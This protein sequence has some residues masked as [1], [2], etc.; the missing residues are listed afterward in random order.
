MSDA[1]LRA[2]E[3][4]ARTGDADARAKW[5]V[6]RVRAGTL[7]RE[8]L[9]AAAY[10][11]DEGARLAVLAE[12]PLCECDSSRR[13]MH[14]RTCPLADRATRDTKGALRIPRATTVWLHNLRGDRDLVVTALLA[15]LGFFAPQYERR[16]Q[17]AVESLGLGIRDWLRCPCGEHAGEVKE[18]SA[19]LEHVLESGDQ[20][21]PNMREAHWIALLWQALGASIGRGVPATVPSRW[22]GLAET[23]LRSG[24]TTESGLRRTIGDAI[25]AR[26]LGPSGKP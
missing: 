8:R 23:L 22:A 21:Y 26:A 7:T 17:S 3:K 19:R 16:E 15:L 13:K 12:R 6:A 4:R 18:R 20:G 9:E 2:L 5:L 1:E 25:V 14:E 24:K 10:A 11:G